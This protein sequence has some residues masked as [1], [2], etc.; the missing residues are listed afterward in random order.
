MQTVQFLNPDL[1]KKLNEDGFEKFLD[2]LG[3][4]RLKQKKV[5][6]ENLLK[7]ANPDEALYRELMLTLGYKNNKVQFLEL[8]MILPYSEICKLDSQEIIERALL[9]TAG[10]SESK[11]GLPEDFDFSLKMEK[12]VWKYKGTRPAN[13]PEKR[14]EGISRLLY[15]SLKEGLCSLFEKKIIENYSERVDKKIAMKFSEAITEIFTTIKA[16]GKTRAMEICFNIILPFFAVIFRQRGQSEYVDFLYKVYDLH[17]PLA[18]NSITRTIETQLFCDKRDNPRRIVTSVR[19]YMGLIML[20][21]KNSGI[22]ENEKLGS[23]LHI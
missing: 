12:S 3:E 10:F 19:R 4:E 18:S 1:Q 23:D 9:Y 16:V 21:Y 8:A 2:S 11:E 17:P 6:M 20:Y 7:I 22:K 5:R 14:I 13:Y 15:C